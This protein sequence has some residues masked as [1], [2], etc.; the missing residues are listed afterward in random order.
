MTDPTLITCKNCGN[1]FTGRFCNFCGEKVYQETDRSFAHLLHEAFHFLTHF[2]GTF[3]R[4]LRTM[5]RQPGRISLDF[6]TGIRKKYFKPLSFFLMMVILYLLFPMFEGLNMKLKFHKTHR[7][8]RE[9]ATQ[10]VADVQ[11]KREYTD[12]QMEEVFHRKSEKL[13][14]F[15]LFIVIPFAALVSYVLGFK[16]RRYFYDHFIFSTEMVS[17]LILYGFLIFPL[18][19]VPLRYI[20]IPFAITELHIGI[21]IW[22]GL[23]IYIGVAARR[24]FG[25]KKFFSVFYAFVFSFGMVFT[26][27][28]IYKFLLFNI[29]I[30][31]I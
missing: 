18:L 25:F 24:F 7:A 13:S 29:A 12:V 31:L 28:V 17:F 4:S 8:Y 30:R 11:L 27:E 15:L 14:K 16:K 5:F 9:Y 1:N 23:G 20:K 26:L 10:K 6:C 21:A 3:L 2:E 22:T 19:I